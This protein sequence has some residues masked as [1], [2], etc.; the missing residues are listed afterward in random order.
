MTLCLPP[1]PVESALRSILGED[2]T[3]LSCRRLESRR[4]AVFHITGASGGQRRE[5]VAKLFLQPG[6]AHEAWI[7][8]QAHT[9]GLPVPLLIGT[10]S[11]TL[12]LEYIPGTNLCDLIERDPDP[13]YGR[14]LG[15]WL[16]QLHKAFPHQPPRRIGEGG[17]EN[18]LGWA[19]LKG[20]PRPRNFIYAGNDHLIGVDFEESHPGPPIEDLAGHC[21]AI[22]DTDPPV[23]PE[24]MEICRAILYSYAQHRKCRTEPLIRKVASLLPHKLRATAARRGNPPA[25]IRAIRRIEEG[26]LTL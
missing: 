26:K 8:R 11:Q 12:I 16:A 9:R 14:L 7:L 3:I 21:S 13:H 2:F 19:L 22:L 5:V 4:N 23:T 25:L 15:A 20:D 24:K 1:L 18:T 10:T 6:L 17:Q